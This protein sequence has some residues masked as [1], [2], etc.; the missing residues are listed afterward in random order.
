MLHKAI[1]WAQVNPIRGL[2]KI[3]ALIYD[4]KRLVSHGWNSFTTHP[5]QARFCSH[6][7]RIHLHAEVAAIVA[8]KQSVEGMDMYVARVWRNGSPALAKPCSD[9]QKALAA[10]KL[11]NVEWTT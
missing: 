3:A 5:L 10:F 9:C 7:N 11:R 2:P 8:A 4:K 1:D 6:P